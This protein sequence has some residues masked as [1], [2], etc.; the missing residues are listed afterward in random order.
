MKWV[1][2]VIIGSVV[3]LSYFGLIF[4]H[5][6]QD[7]GLKEMLK[8]YGTIC[9]IIA[10]MFFGVWLIATGFYFKKKKDKKNGR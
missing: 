8:I 2:Y 9:G 1:F 6:Y 7:L 10:W 4:Y 5:G 3:I